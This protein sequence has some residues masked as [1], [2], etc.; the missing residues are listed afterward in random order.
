MGR[1]KSDVVKD[2][3]NENY[4]KVYVQW[5]VLMRM[6]AKNDEEL[7]HNCWL[8]KWKCNHANLKQWVEISSI[9]FSFSTRNNTTINLIINISVTHAS[10]AKANFDAINNNSCAL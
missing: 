10:K 5:W 2:Q 6:G 4:K 1:A 8:S 7:C 9:L 3:E